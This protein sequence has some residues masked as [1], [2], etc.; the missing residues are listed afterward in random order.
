R[1]RAAAHAA[2]PAPP[3]R[4]GWARPLWIAGAVTGAGALAA[5]LVA[6]IV[7]TPTGGDGAP[8]PASLRP[9]VAA[10]G[11]VGECADP[12]AGLRIRCIEG[13]Q[14]VRDRIPALA[15]APWLV[16]R[17]QAP[18]AL[19]SLVFPPGTTYAEALDALVENVTLTGGLPPGTTL[20]DPLPGRTALLRPADPSQ[21]VAISLAAPFG[22]QPDGRPL[23]LTLTS[24]DPDVVSEG[25]VWPVGTRVAVPDLPACQVVADRAAAPADCAEGEEPALRGQRAPDLPAVPLRSAPVQLTLDRLDGGGPLALTSLRGR[26]VVLAAFASWCEPC[27]DQAGAVRAVAA[28]YA[29]DREVAVVGVAVNDDRAEARRFL[30]DH[31]L[32]MTTLDDRQGELGAT[33]DVVGLPETLVL[34]REG[35]IASRLPGA[36]LDAGTVEREVEAL[37]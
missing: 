37:R 30:R 14:A 11:A 34:D 22:Y 36:L 28:R 16:R 1:A 18:E 27:A 23:G 32:T 2:L 10:L 29:A 13:T 12:P 5:L 8:A 31:R 15:G 3:R 17:A 20:G 25:Y 21:G 26:I 35:R 7:A 19:P 9:D 4:R 24:D 6:L 33:L